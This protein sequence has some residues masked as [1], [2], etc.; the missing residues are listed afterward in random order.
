VLE[1]LKHRTSKCEFKSSQDRPLQINHAR[2]ASIPRT[3]DLN[4]IE[5][6]E[7]GVLLACPNC[8]KRNHRKDEGLG[9]TFVALREGCLN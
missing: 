9:P 2:L 3:L 7:R 5:S 4:A 8:G 6:D 1:A